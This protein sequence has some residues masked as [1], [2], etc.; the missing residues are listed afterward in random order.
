MF[1]N[2]SNAG[3]NPLAGNIRQ[4]QMP[5]GPGAGMPGMWSGPYMPS[6]YPQ[7]RQGTSNMWIPVKNLDEAKNAFVQ[8]GEQKWFM[9]SDQML[10][11]MKAVSSAGVMDFQ[12][13]DFAPHVEPQAQTAA[14]QQEAVQPNFV[15]ELTKTMQQMFGKINELESAVE[16]L[17]GEKEN[18]KSVKQ[19]SGSA[20]RT[21][22]GTK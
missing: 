22:S 9:V 10:F 14:V 16:N 1:N 18:G 3:Y 12:A 19:V 17:K 11:A 2:Q 21:G 6:G 13:F 7:D 15:E 5:Q 8:P 20:S 4:P